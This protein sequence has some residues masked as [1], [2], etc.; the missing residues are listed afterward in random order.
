MSI[1]FMINSRLEHRFVWS[2]NLKKPHSRKHTSLAPHQYTCNISGQ[3]TLQEGPRN[4][5]DIYIY[6]WQ[7]LSIYHNIITS[8]FGSHK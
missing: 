1:N 8:L 6:I 5:R 7:C 2:T 3:R 4:Y